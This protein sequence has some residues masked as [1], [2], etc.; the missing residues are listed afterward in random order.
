MIFEAAKD[1]ALTFLTTRARSEFEVR[2]HLTVKGWSVE[3]IDAVIDWLLEYGFLDD[4][5]FTGAYIRDKLR[6]HP[7]GPK[8]LKHELMAKGVDES[9]VD[10]ELSK[11]FPPQLEHRLAWHFYKKQRKRGRN[12]LQ[13]KRYLAGKGFSGDTIAYIGEMASE[14]LDI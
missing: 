8:K 7:C 6:F 3:Q 10:R 14:H 1:D 11:N 2:N 12:D 9:T 13:A 5:A 4:A